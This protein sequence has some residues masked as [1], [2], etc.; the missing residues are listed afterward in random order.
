MLQEKAGLFLKESVLTQVQLKPVSRVILWRMKKQYRL[1]S[2]SGKMAKAK[3]SLPPGECLL[4]QWSMQELISS[5]LLGS[6]ENLVY[7]RGK[8]RALLMG[9]LSN[10]VNTTVTVMHTYIVQLCGLIPW[11][12]TSNKQPVIAHVQTRA[13][14]SHNG[15]RSLSL[16][17][18]PWALRLYIEEQWQ[19]DCRMFWH[20]GFY[21]LH[22]LN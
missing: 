21:Q 14:V 16:L 10:Y 3:T 4:V 9:E 8:I 1:G 5:I 11:V 2:S 22:I 12:Y 13:S 7:P 6:R 15:S 19:L 20:M 17:A 18:V